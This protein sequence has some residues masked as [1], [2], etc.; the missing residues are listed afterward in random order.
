M[1]DYAWPPAGTLPPL[2]LT[3]EAYWILFPRHPIPPWGGFYHLS[4]FF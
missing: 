3:K 4:S 2:L 1:A